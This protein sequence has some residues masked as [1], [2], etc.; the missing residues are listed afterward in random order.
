MRVLLLTF[1]TDGDV[2][3]FVALGRRLL[4]RGHEVALCTADGLSG[5]APAAGVP[6]LSFGNEWFEA[7]RAAMANAGNVR[8]LI[9]GYRPLLRVMERSLDRQWEVAAGFEPDVVVFHPKPLGGPHLAERLGVPGVI[10]SPIPLY[11]ATSAYP[12]AAMPG[13]PRP[14]WP[15]GYWLTRH[16]TAAYAGMLNR[17]RGR[18]GL[19]RLPGRRT[20]ADNPDGSPR[21]T[22]YAYS[23]SVLPPPADYP[24]T[25][26]VTGYWFLD[27]LAGEPEPAVAEF[28][29]AGRPELYLGFGSMA[30]GGTRERLSDAVAG[31]LQRTGVRAVVVTGWGGVSGDGLPATAYATEFVPHEWLLPR[32]DAVVHHGGAGT[33]GGGLR[34]GR[35]TLVC[36]L[37][38]DQPFWG[39]VVHER[40]LGPPP[41]PMKRL[42]AE[43]LGAGIERLLADRS[44]AR[45]AAELGERITGEDG[46][47]VAAEALERIVAA[48]D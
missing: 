45:R 3:P 25:A 8:E 6:V 1:G 48:R 29:A 13:L 47:G 33:V 23:P 7:N 20:D 21:A 39:S 9:A 26:H 19:G 16:A 18:L 44:A 37:L 27:G 36:P 15:A 2:R 22:L 14:L 11:H 31:A 5:P 38:G 17:F 28:V 10:A 40:G 46:L 30:L 12:S 35:P 34:A 32:V 41:I 24:P 43:R 42:T 4:E